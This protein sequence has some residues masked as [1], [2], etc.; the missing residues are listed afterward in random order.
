MVNEV[1]IYGP[2]FTVNVEDKYIL[3]F[4]YTIRNDSEVFA[5]GNSLSPLE[6]LS[7]QGI[8]AEAIYSPMGDQSD[9][10]LLGMYNKVESDYNPA[11]YES[12]TFHA[13]YLLRRNVRLAGEYSFVATGPAGTDYGQFSLGF[14]S[15]F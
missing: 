13:G 8:L 10:Y 5:A 11:D 4:Q 2:D 1:E 15:A 7:T 14:V 6:D 12:M 3:N 9:W